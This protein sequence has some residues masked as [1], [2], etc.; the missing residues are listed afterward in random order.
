MPAAE[1]PPLMLR[2]KKADAA[3]LAERDRS[4]VERS[5]AKDES[6]D[7]LSARC[8]LRFRRCIRK[9]KKR[10]AEAHL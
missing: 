9:R 8:A 1:T 4:S 6:V 3:T 2:R 10:W 5:S 7:R